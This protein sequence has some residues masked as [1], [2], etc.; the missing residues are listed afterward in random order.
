[1]SIILEA[2]THV[3]SQ[4][5]FVVPAVLLAMTSIIGITG[6]AIDVSY[7]AWNQKLLN[8]A[9][10]A[11]ALAAAQDLLVKDKAGIRQTVYCYSAQNSTDTCS[12]GGSE[13]YNALANSGNIKVL[14]VGSAGVKFSA[15]PK[16]Q[17]GVA[18]GQ[19][20]GANVIKVT[21]KAEIKPIFLSGFGVDKFTISATATATAGGSTGAPPINLMLLVDVSGSMSA[22][23]GTCGTKINCAKGGARTLVSKL[24]AAGNNVGLGVFP[25]VRTAGV[26]DMRDC[27]SNLQ[28]TDYQNYRTGSPT[29]WADSSWN[30]A[31]P[32]APN[33]T[34]TG[35]TACAY[36]TIVGMTPSSAYAS[37]GALVSTNLLARA[38]GVGGA[39]CGLEAT[40][41]CTFSFGSTQYVYHTALAQA[42]RQ[43]ASNLATISASNNLKNVIVLLSDGDFNATA[44]DGFAA[45]QGSIS[46]TTLTVSSTNFPA[47]NGNYGKLKVGSVITS[48]GSGTN[49]S[50]G[51][52]IQSVLSGT[53]EPGTTTTY[54][55][56][57]S[58]TV[59]ARRMRSV[60]T[61]SYLNNQCQQAVEA[62]NVAKDAG[63]KIYSIGYGIASGGCDTDTSNLSPVNDPSVTACKTMQWIA[64]ETRTNSYP[65]SSSPFYY[66]TNNTCP[67]SVNTEGSLDSLFSD[68][69]EGISQTGSR[70]V[71]DDEGITWS[72]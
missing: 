35:T 32:P 68:I 59:S 28:C 5:G 2:V 4:R 12:G 8:A 64:G 21:Q 43:A 70:G 20:S 62:A 6:L 11:A 55:V 52:T 33:C 9:V 56:S 31:N 10:D 1:M 66:S 53:G 13:K 26:T 14:P 27:T 38:I 49:V 47:G 18:P 37:G 48:T 22:S 58:Q 57:I 63:I 16:E 15:L 46:G 67:S 19:L 44:Y 36:S 71:P 39:S 40:S 65:G 29:D 54:R 25:P 72:D 69:A 24:T 23:G 41:Y 45:F 61:S 51:T 30:T 7:I 17:V 3:G 50:T 42:I 34:A 60:S